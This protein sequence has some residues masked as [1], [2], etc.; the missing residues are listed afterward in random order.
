M[1]GSLLAPHDFLIP[2]PKW[3]L[4]MFL[5]NSYNIPHTVWVKTIFSPLSCSGDVLVLLRHVP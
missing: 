1:L 3:L 4:R 5:P 2:Y